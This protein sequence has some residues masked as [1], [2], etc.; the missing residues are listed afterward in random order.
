MNITAS[1]VVP[2]GNKYLYYRAASKALT[3]FKYRTI[4]MATNA[5]QLKFC[6]DTASKFTEMLNAKLELLDLDGNGRGKIVTVEEAMNATDVAAL[7]ND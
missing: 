2:Y 4:Y 3:D 5:E 1:I 7:L 6:A